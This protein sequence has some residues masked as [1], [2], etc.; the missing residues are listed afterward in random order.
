M[1]TASAKGNQAPLIEPG[2]HE[3]V[4]Y[5]VADMGTVHNEVYDV[6]HRK[7]LLIWELP[8]QRIKVPDK[9]DMPRVISKKYTMSLHE[10]AQMYKDLVS[11]RTRDFTPEEKKSFDISR[12][13]GVSCLLNIVHQ[14]K[15]DGTYYATISSVLPLKGKKLTPENPKVIYGIEEHGTAIPDSLPDWVV[16]EIKKSPEYRAIENPPYQ[17]QPE[18]EES[19]TVM[20]QVP[21]DGIP[22][23]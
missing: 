19:E 16:A 17:P 3:A 18:P 5:T 11:W 14:T 15:Q 21:D 4:C 1:L 6:D 8:G 23:D 13:V 20:D 7:I 22:F 10:K 2:L 12:L 9:G